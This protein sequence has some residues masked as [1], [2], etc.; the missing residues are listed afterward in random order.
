MPRLRQLTSR[1]RPA[2]IKM[3]QLMTDSP[4]SA[5]AI[6]SERRSSRIGDKRGHQESHCVASKAYEKILL[7]QDRLNDI[8][9]FDATFNVSNVGEVTR[10][11]Y[12]H[13]HCSPFRGVLSSRSMGR[14][15][16][17]SLQLSTGS[18]KSLRIRSWL[19]CSCV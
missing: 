10:V 1:R 14:F 16:K 5:A 15:G 2:D 8:V 12:G 3:N 19:T 4:K 13:F 9:S 6:A 11:R 17:C 18:P 7:E